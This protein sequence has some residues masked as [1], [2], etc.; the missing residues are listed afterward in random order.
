MSSL[1]G[2][3]ASQRII[4]RVATG[5]QPIITRPRGS[6]R[7][8]RMQH[9]RTLPPLACSTRICRFAHRGLPGILSRVRL[10]SAD[11]ASVQPTIARR[12][13]P[14]I[15]AEG[16]RDWD[17]NW[18]QVAG[19]VVLADGKTWSFEDPCLTTWEA[20]ELGRWLNAVAN[21]SV[22]PSPY[23][24]G[25]DEQMLV[26]TEPE[27]GVQLAGTY[28]RSRAST[29]SFQ[30]GS[31]AALARRNRRARRLRLP[32]GPG[33]VSGRPRCGGRRLE[34]EP[35][36]VPAPISWLP[37]PMPGH[38]CLTPSGRTVPDP[39]A[40]PPGRHGARGGDHRPRPAPNPEQSSIAT[41]DRRRRNRR[42]VRMAG[43]V[44]GMIGL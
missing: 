7:S 21:G 6:P 14:D 25:Q 30:L 23:G 35:Q 43:A 22:P 20:A 33:R 8:S 39:A 19:A 5:S 32:S 18:L 36:P 10:R 17:A 29:S 16:D 41:E 24:T 4:T 3:S 38:Q 44:V 2:P 31:P 42:C 1:A 9:D 12:Q 15:Q 34:R 37:C 13:F 11:L 28:C 27:S 26:F 40:L